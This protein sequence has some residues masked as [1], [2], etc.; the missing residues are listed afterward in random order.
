MRKIVIPTDFSAN[1]YNALKYAVELFKYE[2]SEFYILHAFADEVFSN[3][4][5]VTREQMEE[6]R[7]DLQERYDKKLWNIL[8]LIKEYSPN[9]RHSFNTLASFG[10]LIDEINDVVNTENADIV[11]MGTRGLSK[12]RKLTFGT[13]TLQVIK[14]IQCPVL[15]IP[16]NFE[17]KDPENLLFPTD[18]MIPY[19]RR[20][21]K[22]V[23]YLARSF[24]ARV[25]MMY[26]SKFK[27]DSLRQQEN[28][29][30]LKQ[31]FYDTRYNLHIVEAQD[32]ITGIMDQI[33]KLQIDML[34]MVNSRYT[35]LENILYQSTIDKLGLYPRI[36]F[37]VLQNYHRE[38]I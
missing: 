6:S 11:V 12:E 9:P 24:N 33:D 30:F 32:K 5:I 20:E 25:H 27:L 37:L 14:Y 36:P 26:I 23:A 21:L 13:N 1:A 10:N 8:K 34:V 2:T 38:I 3:E 22:L 17:F 19:Q 4:E 15:S 35:Y 7:R 18:F 16:D 29:Q 28:E 31:Q